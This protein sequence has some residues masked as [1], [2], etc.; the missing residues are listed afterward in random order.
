MT[1][2][3]TLRST[4]IALAFATGFFLVGTPTMAQK[5]MAYPGTKIVKTSHSYP[6]LL[7][8]LTKAIK[9]TRWAW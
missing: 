7:D 9:K 1:S 5:P 8:R 4:L 2:S 3:V 6:A